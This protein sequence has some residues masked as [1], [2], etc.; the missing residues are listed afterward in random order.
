MDVSNG[1]N[2]AITFVM[3]GDVKR[4]VGKNYGEKTVILETTIHR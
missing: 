3:D 1:L 2:F 4:D